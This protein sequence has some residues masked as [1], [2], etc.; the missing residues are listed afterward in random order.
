MP[1]VPRTPA[2]PQPLARAPSD[3]RDAARVR[4]L[5]DRS[6][7]AMAVLDREGVVVATSARAREVLPGLVTGR[8]LPDKLPAPLQQVDV[9]G[10]ET[11]LLFDPRPLAAYEELRVGFTAAVSHELRTPLARLLVLLESSARPEADVPSLLERARGEVEQMRELVDDLLFLSEL[12]TGREVVAL[13]GALALPALREAAADLA[14]Q[15]DRAGVT[16]VV[17]GDEDLELPMRPRMLRMIAQNLM[18]NSIRYAGVGATCT[19][20][21]RREGGGVELLAADDGVGVAQEHLDRLFER[22][23]RAD[24]ARSLRGTGLGLAIVKHVVR[25]AGGTVTAGPGPDGGLA[26]RCSFPAR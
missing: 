3:V 8:R 12:E 5:F 7:L 16:L 22:F 17:D 19:V 25:A 24:H 23:Y 15:A 20:S 6:E 18:T 14:E 1:F 4:A 26:V 21:V 9:D 13:G 2:A 10:G 11:L